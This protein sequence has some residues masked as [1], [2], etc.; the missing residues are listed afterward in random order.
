MVFGLN[1]ERVGRRLGVQ[2][3]GS[4]GL[5]VK[6]EACR[7]LLGEFLPEK[8]ISGPVKRHLRT[9]HYLRT[10]GHDYR[11]PRWYFI[12]TN[13]YRRT[14]HFGTIEDGRMIRSRAGE[15]VAEEWQRTEELRDNVE[16]DAFIVMPSHVHGLIR[17][18]DPRLTG[19][20]MSPLPTEDGTPL[21]EFGN[22]VAHSLSTIVGCFK[23]AATRRIH[24][25]DGW[26]HVEVWQSRFHDHIVP[27]QEALHRIRRYIRTNP[28]RGD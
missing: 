3:R 28:Q 20:E 15:I 14:P 13:T 9:V 21:R 8:I 23:A 11:L 6:Y 16:L 24:R 17:L 1:D 26:K 2:I 19:L 7:C 4:S 22:A 27:D 25:L 10:P 18:V 12:T 5:D